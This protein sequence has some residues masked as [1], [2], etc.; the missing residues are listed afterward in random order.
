[1]RR[2]N[3]ARGVVGDLLKSVVPNVSS[4]VVNHALDILPFKLHL[5]CYRFFGS[6]K[7]L[8]NKLVRGERGMNE[9]NETCR[10]HDIAYSEYKDNIRRRI[11]DQILE[12]KAWKLVIASNSSAANE[13]RISG[14]SSHE[15]Q[16]GTR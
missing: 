3:T 6:G 12:D 13:L 11:S 5:S 9:L 7:T 8:E 14:C 10:E 1:M 4:T 15:I 16:I 2:R